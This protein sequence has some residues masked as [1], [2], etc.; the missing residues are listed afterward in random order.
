MAVVV[1]NLGFES[2]VLRC[3]FDGQIISVTIKLRPRLVMSWTDLLPHRHIGDSEVWNLQMDGSGGVGRASRYTKKHNALIWRLKIDL[4]HILVR[5]FLGKI[6][7][8]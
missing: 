2:S 6:N 5:A 4:C 3:H 8:G 7:A 1:L